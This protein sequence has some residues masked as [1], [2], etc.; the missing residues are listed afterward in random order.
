ADPGY[1][2]RDLRLRRFL[3]SQQD[4][5][6]DNLADFLAMLAQAMDFDQPVEKLPLVIRLARE[7]NHP[8][9]VPVELVPNDRISF[10]DERLD[11]ID[12]HPGSEGYLHVK[13]PVA[14]GPA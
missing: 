1:T 8:P 3:C 7:F 2:Q 6:A 13:V 14:L 12:R 11:E 5:R 10:V 4:R 9:C